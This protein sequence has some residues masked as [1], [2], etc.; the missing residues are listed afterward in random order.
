M[1]NGSCWIRLDFTLSLASFLVPEPFSSTTRC[2]NSVSG[3]CII[4]AE[5]F[6]IQPEGLS[7]CAHEASLL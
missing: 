4:E 1:R 3:S 5:A 7:S 2:W 6:T